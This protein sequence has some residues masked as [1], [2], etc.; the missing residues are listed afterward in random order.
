MRLECNCCPLIRITIRQLEY[1]IAVAESRSVTIAAER[2]R[3]SAPSISVAISQLEAELGVPLFIRRHAQGMSLTPH[4]QELTRHAKQVLEESR[5]FIEAANRLSN[6][7]KGSL[8]VGCLSTIA[9][10]LLPKLRRSFTAKFPEVDFHQV[11][12]HQMEI[13]EALRDARMDLALTYDLAIPTDLSFVGLAEL[14]PF[15]LLPQD[16][17]LS[18]RLS[19]SVTDLVEHP[20]ILLDLPHSSDYFLSL[21]ERENVKPTI[22]ERTKDMALLQSMVANGFGY[23]IANY[24]P[25][26][27]EAPDGCKLTFVPLT[28]AVKPI[29]LGLLSSSGA[30]DLPTIRAFFAMCQEMLPEF[31]ET[32]LTVRPGG[33]SAVR[34]SSDRN[35]GR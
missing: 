7:V 3:V 28:G 20:M 31:V 2:E 35:T 34:S 17:L 4:G 13:I 29:R 24:R 21:F 32:S 30:S 19:L 11:E 16:H 26:L 18:N 25:R 12:V 14:P 23:S 27:A 15:V 22:F 33:A 6:T 5:L 9:Q 1:L 8:T 10:V